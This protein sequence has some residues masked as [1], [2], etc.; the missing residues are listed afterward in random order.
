MINDIIVELNYR[1]WATDRGYK[2]ML[3]I[4]RHKIMSVMISFP[5]TSFTIKKNDIRFD[6]AVVQS[7]FPLSVFD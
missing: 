4:Y 1:H 5:V 3:L 7:G 2:V 6:M